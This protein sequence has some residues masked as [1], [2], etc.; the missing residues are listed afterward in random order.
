MV[1]VWNRS[2]IVVFI[3]LALCLWIV[4]YWFENPKLGNGAYMGWSFF[5]A[6][7][8]TA[9][10]AL[11]L[12]GGRNSP[13]EQNADANGEIP[14]PVWSHSAFFVPVVFWPLILGGLSAFLL[15]GG[16]D[17]KDRAERKTPEVK[18]EPAGE[19][20]IH[21]LNPT[22]DT[23]SYRFEGPK[24]VYETKK[25]SPNSYV[26]RKCD[27]G[28]YSFTIM[29]P[30][31]EVIF[32]IP[33]AGAAADKT[34][35]AAAKDT[36]GNTRAYRIVGPQTTSRKDYDEAW[37]LM[38]GLHRMMLVD[39]SSICSAAI[40]KA[41]VESADWTKHLVRTYDGND[42]IEPLYGKDPGGEI[43]TV[44]GTGDDVPKSIRKNERI[45]ILV[46]VA[47]EKEISREYIAKRVLKRCPDIAEK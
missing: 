41:D 47:P 38:N 3:V 45:F 25:V 35:Y 6:A 46:A 27:A 4:S 10:H 20:V 28:T 14:H 31:R 33:S 22:T 5:Y 13:E 23:L 16:D 34:K 36:E 7:I 44:L 39:V 32:S 29:N 2:G 1:L 8:A 18:T 37:V 9:L 24:G 19:R 17:K 15:I 40:T 12:I 30:Q 11:V 21:F 43:Y 42:L 26:T